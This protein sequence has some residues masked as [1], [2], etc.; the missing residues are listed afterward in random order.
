MHVFVPVQVYFD[1]RYPI[2]PYNSLFHSD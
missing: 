2:G 1:N